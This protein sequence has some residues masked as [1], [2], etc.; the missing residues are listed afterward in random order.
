[1]EVAPFFVDFHHFL[2]IFTIF[3]DFH[4]L[5]T[6]EAI[7]ILP[8]F[9]HFFRSFFLAKIASPHHHT[10]FACMMMTERDIVEDVVKEMDIDGDRDRGWGEGNLRQICW[11]VRTPTPLP[12]TPNM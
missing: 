8:R 6:F 12:N 5:R 3:I 11:L 4:D 2:S 10:F 7:Y 1:M 9:T